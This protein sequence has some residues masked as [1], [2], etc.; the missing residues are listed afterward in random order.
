MQ[1]VYL[2]TFTIEQIVLLQSWGDE[3]KYWPRTWGEWDPL[4]DFSY[5]E[6]W[7]IEFSNEAQL[8]EWMLRYGSD[9]RIMRS[10]F[11]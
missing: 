1:V 6:D 7:W 11:D 4:A 3:V 2:T 8:V 10:L 9:T 5:P